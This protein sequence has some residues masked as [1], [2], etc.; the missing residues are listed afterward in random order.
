MKRVLEPGKFKIMIGEDSQ[1][2][3]CS[4][5]LEALSEESF[6]HGDLVFPLLDPVTV[7]TK[8]EMLQ[9]Q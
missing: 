7:D 3:K 8:L 6:S 4:G 5:M 2:I 1:N 9:G